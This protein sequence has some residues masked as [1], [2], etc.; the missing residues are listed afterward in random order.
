M[1]NE[2]ALT[3]YAMQ[4]MSQ[5][6]GM[7]LYGTSEGKDAVVAFNVGDIHPARHRYPTRPPRHRYPNRA[8]LRTTRYGAL[9]RGRN[10]PRQFRPL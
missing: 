7:H 5:I 3:R 6:E 8:P 10:V 1:L 2:Q 9:W 4:Q